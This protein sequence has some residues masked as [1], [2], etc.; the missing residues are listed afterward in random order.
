MLEI[1]LEI[2][3]FRMVK[4]CQQHVLK[5]LKLLPAPHVKEIDKSSMECCT[6]CHYKAKYELFLL[7]SS[8][9]YTFAT[10]N[11]LVENEDH[12]LV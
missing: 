1:K 6:F 8:V 3:G 9:Q 7:N 4:V 5:G 2:G 11:G 10:E 12:V